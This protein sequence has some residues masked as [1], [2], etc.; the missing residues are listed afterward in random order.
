S[1]GRL[2]H[3][4]LLLITTAT[5]DEVDLDQVRSE[6][7]RIYAGRSFRF[8][9]TNQQMARAVID[10][11]WSQDDLRPDA[12]PIYLTCW[13]DDPYSTDLF[14]RFQQVLSGEAYNGPRRRLRLAQAPAQVWSA[15]AGF[16]V[17]GAR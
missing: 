13:E 9:F 1:R 11:V 17:G 5:A 14:N 7:M 12:E 6:L 8:C 16:A 2:A 3:P 10:F 4:P 15:L